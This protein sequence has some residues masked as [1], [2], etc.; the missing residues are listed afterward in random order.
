MQN[1]HEDC[2]KVLVIA[3][4]NSNIFKFS[5]I[6]WTITSVSVCD[7]NTCPLL[8]RNFFNNVEFSI[9]P[10]WTT[11][12]LWDECGCAFILF[13]IPCVAHLTWPIPIFPDKF[14]KSKF[15]SKLSTLP[16]D[17]TSFIKP[18]DRVWQY[19]QSHTL[20]ILSFFKQFIIL[21]DTDLL[22]DIP[23]IPHMNYLFSFVIFYFSLWCSC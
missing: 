19:Q 13:G 23:I 21:A 17:L 2:F 16:S 18:S 11:D 6:K 7:L 12:T 5:V 15:F 10:L 8:T 1:F 9:I 22:L 20:Y 4:C 14:F 3:S